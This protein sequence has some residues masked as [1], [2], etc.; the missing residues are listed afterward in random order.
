MLP[1]ETIAPVGF[2]H[3]L[4]NFRMAI[5]QR[6]GGPAALEIDIPVVVQVPDV[7]ALG[8]ADDHLGGGIVTLVGGAP[9]G[10]RIAQ[11]VAQMRQP[12]LQ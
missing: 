7:I 12:A 11:A 10:G 9:G 4:D 1:L 3:G 2:M 6:I 8:P 5:T